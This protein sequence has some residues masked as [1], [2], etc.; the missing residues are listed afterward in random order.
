MKCNKDFNMKKIWIALILLGLYHGLCFG[1]E[2]K[3]NP[4]VLIYVAPD[5]LIRKEVALSGVEPLSSDRKNFN[6]LS[7][8]ADSLSY[9]GSSQLFS[10]AFVPKNLELPGTSVVSQWRNGGLLATG[11]RTLMP[12]LMQIESG[13]LGLMQNYGKFSLFLGGVANKY[14]YYNSLHTQYGVTGSVSFI[15]SPKLSMTGFGTHYF[16]KPPLMANGMPM[17]PAMIGYYGVSSFGGYVTYQFNETFGMEVG[18][19]AVQ[20]FGTHKYRFQPIVTPTVKIGK[21]RLGFPVGEIMHGIIRTQ[22]ERKK[23]R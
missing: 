10:S 3:V 19:Q 12:G 17:P 22:T 16:G 18:G 20:Q 13:S 11:E 9:L 6:G 2:A 4:D 21:V 1:Q 7:T 15:F 14:G 23:G 5:S 8:P